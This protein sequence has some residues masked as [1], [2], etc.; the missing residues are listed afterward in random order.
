[1]IPFFAVLSMI[2]CKSPCGERVD[3]SPRPHN[4]RIS[5][6]ASGSRPGTVRLQVDGDDEQVIDAVRRDGDNV[7][8]IRELPPLTDVQYSLWDGEQLRCEDAWTTTPLPVRLP[9]LTVSGDDGGSWDRLVGSLMGTR[10]AVF[11]LDRRG[12]YRWHHFDTTDPLAIVDVHPGEDGVRFNRLDERRRD[13]LGSIE[14]FGWDGA[15]QQRIDTPRAHHFFTPLPDGS[16]VYLAIDVR[17]W[18]NPE[19]GLVE[20]VVGDA[21]MERAPDGS[22]REIFTI[23]DH[24]TPAPHGSWNN[25]FY[26]Q[27]RDWSHG[28]GLFYQEG[29][30]SL[31]VS[32]GNIDLILEIDRQSGD[33]LSRIDPDVWTVQGHRFNFPHS[34]AWVG[35]DRLLV[36]SYVDGDTGAVEYRVDREARTLTEVWAWTSS[37]VQQ[38]FLGQALRVDDG[39]TLVNFGASGRVVEVID[40][41]VTWQVD[42]PLG[43][44]FGSVRPWRAP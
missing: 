17:E 5:W 20:S 8:E 11:S 42:A 6:P 37:D 1:M 13:D 25:N 12:R 26:P 10:Y 44:W 7:A 27:G 41:E 33:V 24:E 32:F 34:P 39:S 29:A 19:T 35:D 28:N 31:L 22:V 14:V 43:V 3:L 40:D 2:A 15:L 36:F 18:T 23:W 16:L 21:V 30:D 9:D 38:P 4:H